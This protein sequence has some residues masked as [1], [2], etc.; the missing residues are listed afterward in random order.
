MEKR[1]LKPIGA[2]ILVKKEPQTQPE[3][4]GTVLLPSSISQP[5]DI[6][7]VISTGPGYRYIDKPG[8]SP[9]QVKE[10]DRIV[11]DSKGK[12]KQIAVPGYDNI[13]YF[14]MDETAIL[15]ILTQKTEENPCG[16]S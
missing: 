12:M 9:L 14:I 15:A 10:G 13:H 1:I 16:S 3:S 11:F 5:L 4:A 2:N 8:F 6:G 7:I